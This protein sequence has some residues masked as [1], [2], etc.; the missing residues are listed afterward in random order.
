MKDFENYQERKRQE[1]GEKFD[2]SAL[3]K[4]FIKYFNNGERI[5]VRFSSGEIKRGTVGVTTGW[6]PSFLL[7]LR[8]NSLGSSHLLSEEDEILYI[9]GKHP[10]HKV[11]PPHI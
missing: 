2:P 5:E 7:M 3:A 11:F 10:A 4:K 9:V 8:S 1:Y 6:R